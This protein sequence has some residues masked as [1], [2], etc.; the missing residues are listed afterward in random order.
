[1][2]ARASFSLARRMGFVPLVSIPNLANSALS[3]ATFIL[4]RF[5]MGMVA[6][7]VRIKAAKLE[8]IREGE[9]RAGFFASFCFLFQFFG[10]FLPG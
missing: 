8:L 5:S 6:A 4:S 1:M 7:V 2:L 10:I 9:N 3:S